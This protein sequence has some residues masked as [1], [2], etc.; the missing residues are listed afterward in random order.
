MLWLGLL[1]LVVF[2]SALGGGFVWTDREDI[3]GGGHRL[4]DLDDVPA[5]L[6]SA[7]PAYRERDL[8]STPPDPAA[9]SWQPLTVLSNSLSWGLWGDCAFCFRLE[10][11]LL[12]GMLVLGL[13]A[14][15]RHLLRQRRH[16]NRLAAW[17]AA[18]FAVHPATVTSVAWIGGRPYL[19]VAVLGVWSLVL[20]TRLPATTKSHRHGARRWLLGLALAGM[21]AMLAH[22]SAYLLPLLALLIA[23]FES[24]ERGRHPLGGIAPLRLQGLALYLGVLLLLIG[25]RKLVL[26]G[27][28]FAGN[29]PTDSLFNNAG[30][31]L[32]HFW[33]LI[34]QTL[35]PAEPII[36]DAWPVTQTWGSAEAAAFLG[37]LVVIGA[38]ATGLWLRHPSALGVA[39]FLLWL[40][41]GVGL[42]PSTH[43]HSSHTLYLATWGASFAV[44]YALFLLWR[45]VGRQLV[46]GSEAVM[47]VPLI[48]ILAVIT[49]FSNAR[50]WDHTRL[51]E[52]EI[53]SDPHYMEGRLELAKEALRR[54][55]A[56]SALNHALAAIEA[57]RDDGFTGH[58]SARDAFFL[59]GRAQWELGLHH[60]AAG[61]FDAA[62][63]HRPG[64][65]AALYW[66]GVSRLSL[67]E[68]AAAE[69]GL[70]GALAANAGLAEASA[71][72]GVALAGQQRYIEAYPLLKEAIDRGLGNARRHR[73]LAL[74]M[75]DANQLAD[76]AAQLEASLDHDED[77][78]ERARLAW[79]AWRLG[80]V[81]KAWRD[82]NMAL[83]FEEETSPYVAW[84]Q[85]QLSRPATA[86]SPETTVETAV[87]GGD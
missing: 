40:I 82:L 39:W 76:A 7:R 60:E 26:G 22:E 4:T 51:F 61:S 1:V 41:P 19:L 18:L 59:L 9:G 77:P 46:P 21:A 29:Y 72:L 17:A 8:S 23:A 15:G 67:E 70:R 48:L 58:W 2:A 27:L 35:L 12:H 42:F 69:E 86:K 20:F 57:S 3:L 28:E 24:R 79:V 6:S 32:R 11:V 65:S 87:Q 13:Y 74:T 68:Y 63:E 73:A 81:D 47:F 14:L 85:D 31:A 38:T 54:D 5:A 56:A 53:A 83:Q 50:L 34:E 33:F 25:Y 80:D 66:L 84:V 78:V 62:L 37:F 45:P 75:I 49:G 52:S 10:N 64:D 44:T 36:S 30:T 55:D 16:G 43:Y 71:D